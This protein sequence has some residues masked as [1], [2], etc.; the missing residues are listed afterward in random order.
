[1]T[2]TSGVTVDDLELANTFS[3]HK[4]SRRWTRHSPNGQHHNQIH[5]ILVRKRFRSG[6]NTAR[7][8]SFPGADIGSDNDLL[9][10][11]FHFR[12]KRTSKP[13][14]TR[15]KLDLGKL[16]D[17]NV[18]E[19]FH[20]M[21]GEKFAPLTIMNS[22]NTDM[23]SM[24][25][26]FNVAVTET[27]SKTP[28]KHR[29]M[30]KKTGSLQKFLICATKGEN[31]ERKDSNLKELRSEVNINIKSC[32]KRANENWIGERCSEIEEN[33]RKSNSKRAYRLVN[34]LTTV[35]L[36]KAA[37]VQDRSGKCLTEKRQILN[38]WTEHCSEL[39]NHKANGDQSVLKCP[40]TD[41]RM[42]TPSFA[43]KWR[44][45]DNHRRKGSQLESITFQQNRSKQVER[46]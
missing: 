8:R 44:L 1:M 14:H 18:L 2:K 13:K 46:M 45:Q 34:D 40:Q 24:I 38:R 31:W 33:L 17:S 27:A 43:K 23:D 4:S 29:Q 5:H 32:M 36:G 16:K 9:M 39:Y 11:I 10:M 35:K 6:V 22:E 28:G 19:T 15:L 41:K 26:T 37:A 25:T 7:T 12:L 30:K 20:G 21:I 3:H 42:T